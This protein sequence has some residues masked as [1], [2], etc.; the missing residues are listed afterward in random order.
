M[1]DFRNVVQ[2]STV[3]QAQ[4]RVNHY[5]KRY[6]S[7]QPILVFGH[8]RTFKL[9]AG[10]IDYKAFLEDYEWKKK[11]IDV[12]SSPVEMYRVIST[13]GVRHPLCPEKGIPEDLAD[14]LL[15]QLGCYADISLSAR[16]AGSDRTVKVYTSVWKEVTKDTWDKFWLTFR[17]D[18]LNNMVLAEGEVD[19]TRN[20][21]VTAEPHKL[22]DGRW[23]GYH[24]GWKILDYDTDI[25]GDEGWGATAGRR[26]KVCYKD[27]ILGVAIARF[28]GTRQDNTLRVYNSMYKAKKV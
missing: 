22:A 17:Q 19:N 23:Q 20:P 14:N 16:I 12:R 28:S 6:G 1:H 9:S 8:T 24:R 5:E 4:E 15:Q 7:F 21:F 13:N 11:K 3:S 18:P 25:L 10:L 27:G 2:Y 26:I